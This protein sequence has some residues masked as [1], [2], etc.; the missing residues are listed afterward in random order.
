MHQSFATNPRPANSG[1]LTLTLFKVNDPL[2]VDNTMIKALQKA[3]LLLPQ[4]NAKF[5]HHFGLEI[6][7]IPTILWRCMNKTEVITLQLSL[8]MP[9]LSLT[10]GGHDFQ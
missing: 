3:S 4:A 5:H 1:I 7:T 2:S 6:K 9:L 10:Q 8:A